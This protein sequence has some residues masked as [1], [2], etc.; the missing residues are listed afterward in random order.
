MARKSITLAAAALAALAIGY[1]AASWYFGTQIAAAHAEMDARIAAVPYLKLIRHDYERG[2]F[3]ASEILTIE[4]PASLF[5][6]PASA[7]AAPAPPPLRVTIRTSIEHGP[8]A[9]FNALA[10][11]RASSRIE[12]EGPF[13]EV[14]RE[15][16]GGKPALEIHTLY[17]FRGGGHSTVTSPAFKLALPGAEPG[18]QA[19]LSGDGLGM[20]V[21]FGKSLGQYTLTG[22]A[23]RFEL[24]EMDGARMVMTDLRLESRQQRLFPDEPLL[25]VGTQQLTLASLSI[26][27]GPGEGQ[28]AGKKI[29]LKEIKYDV[30]MPAEGEFVDILARIGAATVQVGEQNYGPANYEFSLKHL[31]AR[32][33][34]ALNRSLMAL[35]AQSWNA[36]DAQQML[37]ALAP[38]KDQLVALLV[39]TPVVSIERIGFRTPDGEARLG[40]S[41]RLV[42][43]RTEDFANPLMLLAK[44]DAAADIAVPAALLSTLAA[45]QAAGEE[46]AQVLR[47]GAE[48]NVASLVRQGYVIA[49][50][51][52][53][54]SSLTFKSGQL[55]V[56]GVPFNPLAMALQ[57]PG[58]A[59][60]Q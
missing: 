40:A 27:A 57:P 53:L 60:A 38:L 2:P 43:A 35:H 36:Q 23:P 56:N 17:D 46:E 44:L 52:M 3:S 16:F 47:Q 4:V 50:G 45:G 12:V 39:D 55:Q 30:H 15:A 58:T 11:G 10:A 51:N 54:K 13:G 33:L 29:S 37:Q 41:V 25:Y 5:R 21:Q 14:V 22:H 6:A 28:E 8:L 20:A 32:K 1:P 42:D 7:S 34:M 48:H 18:R 19:S 26:H 31:H 24:T 9:G 59:P 49:D